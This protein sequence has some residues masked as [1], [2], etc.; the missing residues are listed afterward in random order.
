[1]SDSIIVCDN[2]A[3]GVTVARSCAD[4]EHRTLSLLPIAETEQ[5][6]LNRN[7]RFLALYED[8]YPAILHRYIAQRNS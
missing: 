1:M 6:G 5:S 4:G 8:R 3:L 7:R 2:E